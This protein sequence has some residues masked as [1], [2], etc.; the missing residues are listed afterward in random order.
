[1]TAKVVLVS[2]A[3]DEILPPASFSTPENIRLTTVG[4]PPR[5]EVHG[6]FWPPHNPDYTA[7]E[8]TLPPLIVFP[9]GGPT[10]HTAPGLEM[11]IQYFTSRGYA[12]FAINYTGSSGHGKAYREALFGEWGIVDRDDVVEAIDYLASSGRVD[13]SRV[14]IEGGSAGG[15][16]VLC[17]LTWHPDKFAGGICYCGVS[18]IQGLD[19]ETHKMESHYV[20][21]LL[22]LGGKTK[23]EREELFRARSPLFHAENI[24]APLLLVH[25]DGDTVVPIAQSKEIKR[26]IEERGGDVELIV[27]EGEGHSF[28]RAESWLTIVVEGEKWWRKTLLRH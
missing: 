6:F 24:R 11:R 23:A 26:K 2:S 19:E 8:G 10:G 25:G 14:G 1:M 5:H 18:D 21:L 13:R 12:Y 20:E 4:K 3:V 17:S 16:N 28:K 7:P 22:K 15:Y 27:L 9:H